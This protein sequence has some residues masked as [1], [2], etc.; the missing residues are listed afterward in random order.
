MVLKH[1]QIASQYS[2][3]YGLQKK[4]DSYADEG[5]SRITTE[6]D[7]ESHPVLLLHINTKTY[8]VGKD[9]F[10]LCQGEFI[11]EEMMVHSRYCWVKNGA[12]FHIFIMEI[13]TF[14]LTRK[15]GHIPIWL[16]PWN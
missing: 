5:E 14:E 15:T 1:D 9:I 3:L 11:L 13:I 10:R 12:I 16:P 2:S 4:C 6:A 8:L 7:I